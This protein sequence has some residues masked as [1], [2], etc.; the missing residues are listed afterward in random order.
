MS[1][2]PRAGAKV[3]QHT[4]KDGTTITLGCDLS[5]DVPKISSTCDQGR[6]EIREE[7]NR[8]V[9]TV[10]LPDLMNVMTPAQLGHMA[11]SGLER[12]QN[13]RL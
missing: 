1:E 8:W 4:F 3:Y 7:F 12:I 6:I 5:T 11:R 9:Q 10:V 13:E 2:Q